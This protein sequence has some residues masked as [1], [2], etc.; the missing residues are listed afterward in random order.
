[1]GNELIDEITSKFNVPFKRCGSLI[2]A[3]NE[4]SKK[5]LDKMYNNA[6]KK[7]YK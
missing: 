3:E 4:E 1:M 7:R 2:I 6:I 5:K